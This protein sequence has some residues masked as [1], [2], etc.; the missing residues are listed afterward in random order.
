MSMRIMHGLSMEC[1]VT[2]GVG[3]VATMRKRAM[4][5]VTIVQTVIYPAVKV[6]WTVKPRTGTDEDASVKPLRT[7]IAVGCAIV[8]WDFVVSVRAIRRRADLHRDLSWRRPSRCQQKD[9]RYRYSTQQL[10]STHISPRTVLR[11]GEPKA[12]SRLIK[13]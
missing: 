6:S 9:R 10:P 2:A 4:V 7:V 8:R 12:L 1:L 5:S 11:R 13:L 3:V